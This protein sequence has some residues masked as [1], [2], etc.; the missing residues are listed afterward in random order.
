M[1]STSA[2]T[3]DLV[4]MNGPVLTLDGS[5]SSQ[6][7]GIAARGR[8]I[9]AVGEAGAIRDMAGPATRVIDLGGER[10]VVPGL[11]D[12]HYHLVYA[13]MASGWLDLSHATTVVEI[14]DAVR[15]RALTE[16]SGSWIY[17]RGWDPSQLTDGR[18]PSLKGLD[19]VSPRHPILLSRG[20]GHLCLANSGALQRA[21]IDRETPDPPGGS[22]GRDPETGAPNGVLS[23]GAL[24]LAWNVMMDELRPDDFRVPVIDGAMA[25][26][27]AGVT[28]VHAIL[29]ENAAAELEAIR[30]LD[31]SGELPVR[32][33]AFIAA[34]SI[35][36]VPAEL[37]G[38]RGN[39]AR[40]FGG[41]I[42][43]DGT[44]FAGSAALRRP[45]AD[46]GSSFGEATHSRDKLVRMVEEIV[47]AG[48]KPAVH[49][50]G[51]AMVEMVLDVYT[52]VLGVQG[53]REIRPRIEHATLLAPDLIRRMTDLGVVATLQPRRWRQIVRRLGTARASWVNPWLALSDAGVLTV[54]SSDAPFLERSP[55]PW[56]AM[57]DAVTTGMSVE[58]ALG[59][60]TTNAA[61]ASQREGE[62]GLLRPGLVADL[63]VLS[64]DPRPSDDD[65]R[66]RERRVAH[67]GETKPVMTII[68]GTV[69]WQAD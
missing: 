61:I 18:A 3:P 1:K 64:R 66:D 56:G 25:A 15:A 6:P 20:D 46:R 69:S 14:T 41:K 19:E 7:T 53:A 62:L 63:T 65:T 50:V 2:Q 4:L 35:S 49:A 36:K 40:V 38:W 30:D 51:D 8:Y 13:G 33:D 21:G 32:I 24:Y 34:E 12:G 37:L 29:L 44:L 67:F 10:A 60:A 47:E 16:P 59:T 26:A 57:V 22:I 68:D 43:A 5:G 9:V 31:E 28:Y 23:E 27:R 58:Q 11:A 45:Y 52:E 55:G 17:G 48:L 39:R 54:A 42:F